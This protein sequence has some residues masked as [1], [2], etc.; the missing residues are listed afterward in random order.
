MGPH[1]ARQNTNFV[2]IERV[3]FYDPDNN[4]IFVFVYLA[5]PI[6]PERKQTPGSGTVLKKKRFDFNTAENIRRESAKLIILVFRTSNHYAIGNPHVRNVE[7][8]HR[9]LCFVLAWSM[10]RLQ[11]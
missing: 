8:G 2:L 9:L 5:K 11:R 4:L 10:D 1:Q 3:N 6:A 7:T